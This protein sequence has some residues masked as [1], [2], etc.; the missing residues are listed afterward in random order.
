[1]PPEVLPDVLAQYQAELERA[2]AAPLPEDSD[3]D[4]LQED[5]AGG[6][7]DAHA[8]V[9]DEVL[10]ADGSETTT[11]STTSSTR[12]DTTSATQAFVAEDESAAEGEAP[13]PAA[14]YYQLDGAFR[15]YEDGVSRDIEDAFQVWS[16]AS[17]ATV[18]IGGETYVIDFR[19]MRQSREGGPTAPQ[20]V[21]RQDEEV[22]HTSQ[23]EE[24][25]AAF[26]RRDQEEAARKRKEEE[27]ARKREEE[28]ERVRR[29]EAARKRREEEAEERLCR[30]GVASLGRL[31]LRVWRRGAN[32]Q[33]DAARKRQQEEACD[34]ARR[35]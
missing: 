4:D 2:T 29:E 15:H 28:A 18:S 31:L 22:E 26:K 20:P 1:M 30:V 24:D 5:I 14:W 12:S 6:M 19:T 11:A 23:E 8:V 34:V 25:E 21:R 32:E 17:L 9:G 35:G 27:A 7:C 13:P 16:A 3:D 10:M 33:E